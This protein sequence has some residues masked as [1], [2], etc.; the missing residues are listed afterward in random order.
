MASKPIFFDPTGRRGRVLSVLAWASGAIS[1]LS[2]AAFALTLSIVD[3]PGTASTAQPRDSSATATSQAVDP[4]LLKSAR[5]LAA[6]LREKERT[7][8]QPLPRS[9]ATSLPIAAKL[10]SGRSTSIGFYVNDDDNGYPDLKRAL[11]HLDWFVPSWMTVSGPAMELSTHID[12]RAL[13]YIRKTK[14]EVA[15]LPMIQNAVDGRFDGK[16]LASFLADPSARSAR[17]SAIRTF[18]E[19][20]AFQGVTIDFEN[21]PAAAQPNLARFL[22]ELRGSLAGG[23]YAVVLAVPFDDQSWP[24]RSYADVT[25]FMLLMGYDQHWEEGEPGSIAGQSWFEKT[26]DKR[27]QDLDPSRTIVAIGGY[28]YDWIQG[29]PTVE[30]SFQEAVLSAKD[31]DAKIDFDVDSSNPHFSFVEDGKRHE[32]WFLD[33]ATAFNE[34]HAADDYRPAGYALWR[35]GSEDPSIWSVMGRAYG[36]PPPDELRNIDTAKDVDIEGSGGILRVADSPQTGTRTFETDDRFGDIVD[37]TYT[38]VPTP[39]VIRR[40]GDV[41]GKVALT[42]DDGPDQ[43]W[44]PQILDILK[45]KGVKASFFVIGDNAESYPDLVQRIVAEGHDLGNHTFT[46][47]NLGEFPDVLVKLEINANQRLIEALTGR[48]MRLFRAPY[49]GDTDPTTSDEIVPIEIA[50]SMGSTSVGVSVDPDDWERPSASQIVQRVIDQ[51]NDPNPELKGNIILLHDSGGD[52]S[53]T[54]AA[55]PELID[56]LRAQGYSFVPVS[57]LAG[58]TQAEAMPPV[59]ESSFGYLVDRPVFAT[60]GWLGHLFKSLFFVAI[61]LGIARLLF[62]CGLALRSWAAE[63]RRV[64]PE[65]PAQPH[66]Q[67]VLVPAY[68]EEK[69]IEQ[70]IRRILA[71]DYRNLEI[72][73]IDD[74]SAD[75]TSGVVREHFSGDPRV[76]L[77]TIANGGKA[78]ALNRGLAEAGGDV[79]VA[80]DADT[81]F[82]RDTIRRLVRWFAD[83]AIGAVAGNAKVGNRINI[84]TRWQA[85]EYVTSQNL[86]RRALAALGCVTVVPGAI[87]AW[88]RETLVALGGFPAQTLAEDQD[89]TI[90]LQKSGHKV[91]FDSTAIAWTEAPDTVESLIKQRFR[92]AFGTLQCL[93]KHRDTTFSRR[94]GSLGLVAMPQT[95]LFQFLL[96]ATAPLVDLLFLW[97]LIVSGLDLLE[98]GSQFDSASLQK[99]VLYYA[100]FLMV[101][102]GSAALAFAMER[103]EKLSLLRWLVL[104]RFGYRQLMYY[105]VLKAGLAALFGPMVGWNKLDRKSTVAAD[106][107]SAA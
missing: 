54:V 72:I 107:A 104:Q 82:Q 22:R 105:V 8:A 95:W 99:V 60:L 45:A 43:E 41:P 63:K 100:V 11:P 57:E 65:L 56:R 17:I 1:L 3:W 10:P 86:E 101:D 83:P 4:R 96:T 97:Q 52:R 62:L 5:E 61:W 70:T 48:S 88:R 39:Y 46:H 51:V 53:A 68:N 19:T 34:I 90:A 30:L 102:L 32:V 14:P 38:R 16:G 37:E 55:L 71:S 91:L 84:I 87:G 27:M 75:N 40:S 73:V 94:Y 20:N 79:I 89:L 44:T 23:G 92:W 31:S 85:L 33:G 64:P 18:L 76:K 58:M 42:F 81:H 80:L 49:M 24:Y 98:H 26:L 35:L 93:W 77:I 50:Q 74:G 29:S 9:G 67:T 59:S 7:L 66:L 69:V 25:D 13:T 78:A 103:R 47:P 15:I 21:V 2:I 28:G 106:H 12:D 6:E 36:A